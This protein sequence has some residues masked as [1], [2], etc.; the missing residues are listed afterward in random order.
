MPERGALAGSGECF[1]FAP[2]RLFALTVAQLLDPAL[3]LVE[4]AADFGGFGAL[5]GLLL[6][7]GRGALEPLGLRGRIGFGQP[8]GLPR[9]VLRW[10]LARNLFSP[11]RAN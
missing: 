7:K 5:L 2:E 9:A 11:C 8:Q 1:G 6:T 4:P 10:R 3:L